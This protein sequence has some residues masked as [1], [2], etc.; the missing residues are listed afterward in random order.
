MYCNQKVHVY[1]ATYIIFVPTQTLVGK[2]KKNWKVPDVFDNPWCAITACIEFIQRTEP[3]SIG[4]D[5]G[6]LLRSFV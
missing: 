1:K 4:F 3:Q 6:W 5:P 2:L